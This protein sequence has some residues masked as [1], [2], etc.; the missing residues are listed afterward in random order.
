[1][2]VVEGLRYAERCSESS[3]KHAHL[4]VLRH[5]CDRRNW[6]TEVTRRTPE[7][8]SPKI[9]PS[10]SKHSQGRYCPEFQSKL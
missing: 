1:M 10:I 2:E 3:W 7:V 6:D 9:S 5:V 4:R 8:C